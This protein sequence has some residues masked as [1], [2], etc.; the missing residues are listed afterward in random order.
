MHL[1]AATP[2]TVS[3]GSEAVDLGQTPGDIVVLSAADTELAALSAAHAEAGGP[4]LRLANLLRLGHNLSVD[5]HVDAVISHARLV[6]VR[7]LGGAAYW[8]YGIERVADRCR[9]RGIALAVLPGDDQPDPEL[10]ALCT[11]PPAAWQRLWRYCMH[12][13]AANFRNFLRYAAHLLGEAP[14]WLEPAPVPRAGVGRR[15]E[16]HGGVS[17]RPLAAVVFYRAL[18]QA[19]HLAPVDAL[20]AALERRGLDTLAVY[21]SSLRDPVAAGTLEALFADTPPDV[22][23]N[24]TGFAVSRPGEARSPAPFDGACAPVLQTVFAGATN[25]VW[26]ASSQGL[27][28]RDI[29]MNVAL[30]EVD[31]RILSRAV[32]FKAEAAWDERTQCSVVATEPAGDRVAFVAALRHGVDAVAPRR[33]GRTPGRHRPR[34]LPGAR[35]TGRQRSWPRHSRRRAGGVTRPR[36]RRLPG[37]RRSR[38]RR[39][40]DAPPYRLAPRRPLPCRI[41]RPRFRPPAG[42]GSRRRDRSLGGRPKPIPASPTALSASPSWSSAI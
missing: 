37:E 30:P 29:A 23:L 5:L 10:A 36:R 26:R 38:R 40:A 15:G 19:G 4:S 34:Q 9:E 20:C 24:A 22:I 14:E 1:L 18:F 31:G 16:G 6:V 21:V 27:S 42:S 35:R 39:R 17:G 32:A 28:A 2:G 12:G 13:G 11:L 25:A 7:L 3:D 41:L 33:C 8:P